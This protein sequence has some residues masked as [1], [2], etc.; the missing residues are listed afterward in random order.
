MYF[1]E[2]HVTGINFCGRRFKKL[3]FGSFKTA[4]MIN[5]YSGS[6]W[7]VTESG[8]RKLIKRVYN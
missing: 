8:K 4:N 5:L 1:K 3:T 2:F 6:V 7:G